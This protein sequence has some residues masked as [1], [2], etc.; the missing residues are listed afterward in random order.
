MTNRD[1]ANERIQHLHGARRALMNA[2]GRIEIV[3]AGADIKTEIANT[4]KEIAEAEAENAELRTHVEVLE[5]DLY[6]VIAEGIVVEF[7]DVPYDVAHG[8]GRHVWANTNGDET[9]TQDLADR[10]VALA[11]HWKDNHWKIPAGFSN[12]KFEDWLREVGGL[13]FMEDIAAACGVTSTEVVKELAQMAGY[14][15]ARFARAP[16]GEAA[17]F[18]A[19]QHDDQPWPV[20]Q[21]KIGDMMIAKFETTGRF[22][23][24]TGEIVSTIQSDDRHVGDAIGGKGDIHV[25]EWIVKSSQDI[26]RISED[27]KISRRVVEA[28]L[29]KL[30][31]AGLLALKESSDGVYVHILVKD[32]KTLTPQERAMLTSVKKLFGVTR[33]AGRVIL[34]EPDQPPS[35]GNHHHYIEALEKQFDTLSQLIHARGQAA[36]KGMTRLMGIRMSELF[37]FDIDALKRAETF[38]WFADPIQAV[39]FAA[40]TLPD[41]VRLTRELTAGHSGWWY[42]T[43]PIPIATRHE[44]G[45]LRAIL[46]SWTVSGPKDNLPGV[47]FSAYVDDDE[48]SYLMPTTKWFWPEGSTIAQVIDRTRK[49]HAQRY[50]PG[51]DLA[52]HLDEHAL[53]PVETLI[54]A[55]G[56]MVRYYT[57]GSLWVQQKKLVHAKGHIERHARKRM[58]R[59]AFLRPLSDVQIIQLRRIKSDSMGA[60]E[61]GAVGTVEWQCQWMVGGHWRN[62]FHPSDGH[63]EAKWIDA[64]PKGPKDKPMKTYTARVYVVN[65]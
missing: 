15:R 14:D 2:R 33:E 6:R 62:Q 16:S 60:E 19:K 65:R 58:E 46:W 38:C 10:A 50:G 52:G 24:S 21:T 53:Q 41:T 20:L 49:E 5:A 23:S 25:A 54:A 63:Y 9:S 44:S 45:T 3:Q 57:A 59:D 61:P 36:R 51:G 31:A 17:V 32:I 64:Y 47:S 7:P 8:I 22:E 37:D 11:V 27:L 39:S 43:D 35:N 56:A 42:F 48:H 55:V 18:L 1:T 13:A 29:S 30:E 28:M 34:G 26:R 40:A 12:M 4:E